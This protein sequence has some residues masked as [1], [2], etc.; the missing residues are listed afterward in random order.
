MF[1]YESSC[2]C[3]ALMKIASPTLIDP[4][5]SVYCPACESICVPLYPAVV[6]GLS[7]VNVTLIPVDVEAG[8]GL[9][10]PVVH[11]TVTGFLPPTTKGNDPG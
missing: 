1:N 5:C 4:T 2:Q 6:G 10:P 7:H 9:W 8:P 3:G 11:D